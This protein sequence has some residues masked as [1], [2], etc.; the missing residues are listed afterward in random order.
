VAAGGV[1]GKGDGWGWEFDGAEGGEGVAALRQAQG[2]KG[3]LL[4]IC[5]S[6]TYG[7]DGR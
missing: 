7:V 6:L 4:F 3:I 5:R 2:E 1:C